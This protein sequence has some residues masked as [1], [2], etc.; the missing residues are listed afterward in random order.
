MTLS[1]EISRRHYEA[2]LDG[3]ILHTLDRI[4]EG[5]PKPLT[6]ESLAG[7]DQF[8]FGGL[9]ATRELAKAAGIAPGA[10]VLDVGCGLGGPARTLAAEF[11]ADVTGVDLSPAYVRIAGR[12]SAL[13]DLGGVTRF[14]VADAA[15]LPFEAGAFDIVW[16]QHAVMNF[17]DRNA[18]YAE[19]RRVLKPGGQ[20]AFHDFVAGAPGDGLHFPVPWATDAAGSHLLT[21][22]ETREA[23]AAQ[24]FSVVQWRQIPALTPGQPPPSS[25]P[26]L[27]AIMGARFQQMVQNLVRNIAEEHVAVVMGI[28]QR[29]TGRG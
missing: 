28:C 3:D 11:G 10:Q 25:A 19:M 20:L 7:L 9:P 26:G 21:E 13:S 6:T 2:N 4:L 1:P 17:P 18:A 15:A 23:L 12:L 16:T 8:H 5:L 14:D 27:G 24:G 22:A 29:D